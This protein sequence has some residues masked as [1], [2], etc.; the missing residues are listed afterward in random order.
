MFTVAR[1][2]DITRGYIQAIE[3]M[4]NAGFFIGQGLRGPMDT[5]DSKDGFL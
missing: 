2:D 3:T 5:M 1:F 4:S